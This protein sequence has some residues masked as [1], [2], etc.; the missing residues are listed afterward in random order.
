MH[1]QTDCA[2]W[3]LDRGANPFKSDNEGK[4]AMDHA[5]DNGYDHCLRVIEAYPDEPAPAPSA[6]VRQSL[7]TQPRSAIDDTPACDDVVSTASPH[8]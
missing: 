3:L 6:L 2:K 5:R 1:G 8:L 4:N 7:L